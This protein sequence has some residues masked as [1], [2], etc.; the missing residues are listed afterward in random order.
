MGGGGG[1]IDVVS[2]RT[3]M[4]FFLGIFVYSAKTK[5]LIFGVLET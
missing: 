1:K 3:K 2:K 5:Q 4:S